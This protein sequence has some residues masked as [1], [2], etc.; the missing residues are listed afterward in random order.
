MI[1]DFVYRLIY[2]FFFNI[3]SLSF[4]NNFYYFLFELNANFSRLII[5]INT[6]TNID[7][8]KPF[9][10]IYSIVNINISSILNIN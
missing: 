1:I 9:A 2:I 5:N 8:P 4:H 10:T 7:G 3:L 6:M